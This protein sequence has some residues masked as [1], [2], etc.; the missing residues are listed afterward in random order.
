MDPN[1]TEQAVFQH[2]LFSSVVSVAAFVTSLLVGW[3]SLRREPPLSET[4]IKEFATKTEVSDLRK[5][6]VALREEINGQLQSGNR[7]FKDIERVIGQLEGALRMCPL[8]CGRQAVTI[9]M[10]PQKG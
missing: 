5:E 2:N 1:T 7:C 9:T 10:P 6:I 8:L 3:R 4:V